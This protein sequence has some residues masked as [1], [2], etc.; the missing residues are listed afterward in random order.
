M[1]LA[2]FFW[3]D[4]ALAGVC[5]NLWDRSAIEISSAPKRRRLNRTTQFFRSDSRRFCPIP[6]TTHTFSR[7]QM[8]TP[9]YQLTDSKQTHISSARPEAKS[10][11]DCQN[12]G[13]AVAHQRHGS[14]LIFLLLCPITGTASVQ[15]NRSTSKAEFWNPFGQGGARCALHVSGLKVF[16]KLP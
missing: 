5:G 16:T 1:A 3:R 7:L 6:D 11:L 2:T 13:K 8:C 4:P 10:S 12:S 9:L 14:P 15:S